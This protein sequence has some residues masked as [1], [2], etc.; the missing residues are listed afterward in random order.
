MPISKKDVQWKE[1]GPKDTLY[2]GLILELLME[3]KDE[4]YTLAELCDFTKDK[5]GPDAAKTDSNFVGNMRA[6]LLDQRIAITFTDGQ[7]YYSL[8]D[9][10]PTR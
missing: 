1:Y 2:R 4:A 10:L 5:I 6:A 7:T 9:N 8:K 3:H